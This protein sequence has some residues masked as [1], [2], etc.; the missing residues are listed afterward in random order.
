MWPIRNLKQLNERAAAEAHFKEPSN[1]IDSRAVTRVMFTPGDGPLFDA[2]TGVLNLAR[3]R[4]LPGIRQRIAGIGL[5]E[6]T[7]F[8]T[9]DGRQ[10]GGDDLLTV[11]KGLDRPFCP[12]LASA[13]EATVS[14]WICVCREANLG[15]ERRRN[16]GD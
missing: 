1:W 8:N 10:I 5:F 16:G 6:R 7:D 4:L 15:V 14:V 11:I 3:C 9:K 12:V 2:T 13:Q